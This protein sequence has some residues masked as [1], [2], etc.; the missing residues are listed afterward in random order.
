MGGG[1]W[2]IA[3][4]VIINLGGDRGFL[5]L[6]GVALCRLGWTFFGGSWPASC[7]MSE[8]RWS[9][10]SFLCFRKF[11]KNKKIYSSCLAVTSNLVSRIYLLIKFFAKQL[12]NLVMGF[13]GFINWWAGGSLVQHMDNYI[14]CI[15]QWYMRTGMVLGIPDDEYCK[16]DLE[17]EDQD[18]EKWL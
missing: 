4:F 13:T 16:D 2:R 12:Y 8:V 10:F 3:I 17:N 5:T 9:F 1:G 14:G 7:I 11:G 6:G 15:G 18:L